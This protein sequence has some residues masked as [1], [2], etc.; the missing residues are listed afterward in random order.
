M[1]RSTVPRDGTRRP[2]ILHSRAISRYTD[3]TVRRCLRQVPRPQHLPH[4]GL[5]LIRQPPA[6]AA[7]A[8]GA[9]QQVRDNA[10]ARPPPADQHV[11]L[12]P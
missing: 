11:D 8:G 4:H 5:H 1:R 9:G 2:R 12:P 10:L 6:A 3:A 7:A